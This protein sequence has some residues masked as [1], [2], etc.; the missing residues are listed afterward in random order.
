MSALLIEAGNQVTK[1]RVQKYGH[2][3]P[4]QRSSRQ[5]AALVPTTL[6]SS[7]PPQPLQCRPIY[8]NLVPRYPVTP[9]LPMATEKI[10]Q[11]PKGR[12]LLQLAQLVPRDAN[13]RVR[14][15]ALK[16][17]LAVPS[18]AGSSTKPSNLCLVV[19]ALT[20]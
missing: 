19:G 2:T 11:R 13:W 3:F 16:A 1:M 17:P 8:A 7:T 20:N 4:T 12:P 9:G 14:S 6:F 5:N 10:L 18:S 15:T